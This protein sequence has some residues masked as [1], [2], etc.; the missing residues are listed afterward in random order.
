MPSAAAGSGSSLH[1]FGCLS[2]GF[3]LRSDG[4][5]TAVNLPDFPLIPAKSLCTT[6]DHTFASRGEKRQRSTRPSFSTGEGTRL[7]KISFTALSRV[8]PAG[9]GSSNSTTPNAS[10]SSASVVKRRKIVF[11]PSQMRA[12]CPP[13]PGREGSSGAPQSNQP[14]EGESPIF[15]VPLSCLAKK[16]P[17][18]P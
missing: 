4:G 11:L 6:Y 13:Q 18:A 14:T 5:G 12:N 3:L 10:T 17:S 15:S 2:D 8:I 16:S 9:S 1:Q 7:S